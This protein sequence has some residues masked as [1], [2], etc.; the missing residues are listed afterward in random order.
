MRRGILGRSVGY[1]QPGTRS[2]AEVIR[3]PARSAR[4]GDP[5][6]PVRIFVGTES[7][8]VAMLVRRACSETSGVTASS[9]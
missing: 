6:A 4:A 9:S 2:Q 8:S 5:R 1:S 3:L 7:A